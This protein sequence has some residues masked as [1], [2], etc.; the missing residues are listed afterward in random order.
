MHKLAI[1]S[2]PDATLARE[3]SSA[4][5]ALQAKG[6]MTIYRAVVVARDP[7]GEIF[8]QEIARRRHGAASAGALIGGLAGFALDP[9][10][11]IIGAAGG[12]ILGHTAKILH[13][14]EAAKILQKISENL[15]PGKAAALVEIEDSD[16]IKFA[17]TME[18]FG[19]V[20]LHE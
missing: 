4:I 14:H 19:G 9:L 7:R 12:A 8:L 6:K 10:A 2:F 5:K 17:A 3:A 1:M 15:R 18:P 13:D 20:V 11:M 16:L